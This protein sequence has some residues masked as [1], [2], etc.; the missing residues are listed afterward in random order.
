MA[1]RELGQEIRRLVNDEVPAAPWLEDRVMAAVLDN[2]AGRS[3]AMSPFARFRLP[4]APLAAML[5]AVLSIGVLLG[6]HLARPLSSP[7][8]PPPTPIEVS[9]VV[10]YR[11]L[12][13]T[14]MEAIYSPYY[15]ADRCLTKETCVALVLKVRGATESM[16]R[17]IVATSAPLPVA[18]EA[19]QVRV[20]AEQFLEQLDVAI[21][22]ME[23]PG[24]DFVAI[25]GAPSIDGLDLAVATVNCW[26]VVPQ[27][28]NDLTEG[29]GCTPQPAVDYHE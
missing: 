7:S 6:S 13:D 15:R 18:G 3:W 10:Q 11:A 28:R 26:P 9:A 22:A 16:L 24:S 12:L 1:D 21:V 29:Y 5:I 27:V 20:K 17:D 19:A 23:V 8:T 4:M 2:A 25:A 14:D